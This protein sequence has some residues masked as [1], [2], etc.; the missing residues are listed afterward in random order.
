MSFTLY[1]WCTVSAMLG[2][3]IHILFKMQAE[4]VLSRKANLEWSARQF[5]KDDWLTM[6]SNQ[7]VILLGLVIVDE[8]IGVDSKV[9]EYIKSLFSVIG[10]SGNFIAL[11]LFSK[12]TQRVVGG[13]DY[14]TT[15]I[16]KINNTLDKPTPAVLPTDKPKDVPK[17]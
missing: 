17:P 13:V 15:E 7:L 4:K 3:S 2:A 10:F 9:M 1:I 16:D 6:L 11:S 5:F 8:L 12:A 14:K